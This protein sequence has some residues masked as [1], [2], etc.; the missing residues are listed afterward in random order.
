MASYTIAKD[1]TITTRAGSASSDLFHH[2]AVR[3][4]GTATAGTLKIE[5]RIHGST[6]FNEH[7]T[8]DLTSLKD[9]NFIAPIAEYRF[10]PSGVTGVD[11]IYVVDTATASGK[12]LSSREAGFFGGNSGTITFADDTDTEITIDDPN[13]I[14][15][16]YEL[17][18]F[19]KNDVAHNYRVYLVRK[20]GDEYD[21][22][23]WM[24]DSDDAFS[25][26]TISKSL[27]ALPVGVAQFDVTANGTGGDVTID[28]KTKLLY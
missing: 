1:E 24:K 12:P 23:F 4:S 22:K 25:F 26:V 20:S 3:P 19:I 14:D 27:D 11:H 5:Y 9:T 15:A 8:V 21:F 7:A 16:H 10:T 13:L 17:S 18:M 2:I 6:L 28:Y